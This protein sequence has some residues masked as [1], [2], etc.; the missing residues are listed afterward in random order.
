M[1][2]DSLGELLLAG[3]VEI[4]KKACIMIILLDAFHISNCC[5]KLMAVLDIASFR[6]VGSRV[7]ETV[8]TFASLVPSS[9]LILLNC[10]LTGRNRQALEE[11]ASDYTSMKGWTIKNTFIT[12]SIPCW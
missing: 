11:Y 7:N 3:N 8:R 6:E 5:L 12:A 4:V 1:L 2:R 9:R 10:R